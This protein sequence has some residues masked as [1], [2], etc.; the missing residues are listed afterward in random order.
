MFINPSARVR[1]RDVLS[2]I[3]DERSIRQ[4]SNGM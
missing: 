2:A 3:D 1:E 4:V